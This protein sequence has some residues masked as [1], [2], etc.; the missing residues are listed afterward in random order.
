MNRNLLRLAAIGATVLCLSE[1]ARAQARV[2]RDVVYGMYSGLALLMDVHHPEK[3]NG[4]GIVHISGSGW[5]APVDFD[6]RPL[7]EGGAVK[8]EGEP[9]VQAGYTVFTLN[10]RATPRF[11]YPAPVEDVQRAVRFIRHHAKKYGIDPARIGAVGGSS[12]GYLVSMLGVLDGRGD[13]RSGSPIE[14][15]SAKVQVVVARATPSDLQTMPELA[16]V[17][18]FAGGFRSDAAGS[19]EF[20]LYREA[21]P[22]THVSPDDPPFLIVHGDADPV[23]PF[24]QAEGFAKAFRSAGVTVKLVTIPGGVHGPNFGNAERAAVYQREIVAWLGTHLPR[25]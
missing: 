9:L 10:H 12:G 22:V 14:R 18:Q 19:P 13:P 7:K 8:M 1:P 17:A 11:H 4:Y 6:A 23:I 15:E 16:Q 20:R 25:K 24:A 5:R 2:E 3:P 21:S